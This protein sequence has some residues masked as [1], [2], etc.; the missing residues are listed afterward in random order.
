MITL[1]HGDNVETSRAELLRLKKQTQGEVRQ[2][3]GPTLGETEL[4]EA[5]EAASLFGKEK[6]VVIENLL[7]GLKRKPKN[8]ELLVKRLTSR[9]ADTHIIL[10]ENREISETSLKPLGSKLNVKLFKVPPLIFQFL[11]SLRQGNPKMPLTLFEKILNSQQSP[12]LIFALIVRRV[13]LLII[14]KDNLRPPT[15]GEWQ[16]ARLTSQAKLF[17]M[18]KLLDM[19]ARL[20]KLEYSFKSGVSPFTFAQLIEQFLIDI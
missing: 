14:I 15:L 4:I 6:L 18:E 2:L 9:A 7:S 12:E 10:W 13:R 5:L 11:D 8:L 3:H 19:H 17:T 16:F 1:L 20:L